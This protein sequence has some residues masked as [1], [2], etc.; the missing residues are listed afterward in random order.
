MTLIV[1]HAE[2]IPQ[3]ASMHADVVVPCDA[4]G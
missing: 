2:R 3:I 1:P 4:R